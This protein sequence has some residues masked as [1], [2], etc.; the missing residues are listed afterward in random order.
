[1]WIRFWYKVN[2]SSSRDNPEEVDYTWYTTRPSD[3]TLKD[4]A[5]ENVPYWVKESERGYKYGYEDVETLPLMDR[6]MLVARYTRQKAYAEEMLRIL[7][8]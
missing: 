1:M 4:T 5:E 8:Q 2:C 3:A 7:G 6:A